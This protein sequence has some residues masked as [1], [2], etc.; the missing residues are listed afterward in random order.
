MG[1]LSTADL[2]KF[3][4][5]CFMGYC[6]AQR[7][8]LFV[9]FFSFLFVLLCLQCLTSMFIETNDSYQESCYNS[10]G[11]DRWSSALLHT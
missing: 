4:F 11:L 3:C 2:Q 10:N 7:H 1:I 6:L 9:L 8:Q 5:F